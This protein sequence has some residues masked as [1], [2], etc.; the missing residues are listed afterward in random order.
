M[1]PT[2]L[3]NC[4]YRRWATAFWMLPDIMPSTSISVSIHFSIK[5]LRG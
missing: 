2:I 1:R 4:H 5:V 3:A